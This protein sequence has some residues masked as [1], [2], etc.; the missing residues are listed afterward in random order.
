[1][2]VALALF[3]ALCDVG[4]ALE[5]LRDLHPPGSDAWCALTDIIMSLDAAI[6]TLVLSSGL[7]GR[8]DDD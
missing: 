7:G 1:M 8:D 2:S 5:Q 4:T 3:T 6:D